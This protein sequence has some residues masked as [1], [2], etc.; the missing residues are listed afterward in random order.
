MSE[1]SSIEQ[2][3]ISTDSLRDLALF[4]EGM[5]LGRGGNI[6]PLGTIVIDDLWATIKYMEGSGAFLAKRDLK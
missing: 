2:Q 6:Q 3:I 1:K 5:K 4:L